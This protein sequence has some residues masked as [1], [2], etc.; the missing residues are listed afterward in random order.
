MTEEAVEY[1]PV[2]IEPRL[3]VLDVHTPWF[4]LV[5]FWRRAYAQPLIE[6][7]VWRTVNRGM[8]GVP[9]WWLYVWKREGRP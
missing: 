1:Q 8:R 3:R 7:K 5:I 2:L 4:W 6:V 9:R